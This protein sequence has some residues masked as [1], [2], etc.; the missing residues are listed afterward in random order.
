MTSTV[1]A[2]Q[3]RD[4]RPPFEFGYWLQTNVLSLGKIITLLLLIALNIWI[5]GAGM[6]A[7]P[8]TTTAVIMLWSVFGGLIAYNMVRHNHV[9]GTLREVKVRIYTSLHGALVSLFLL[10][11]L[12]LALYA[13]VRYVTFWPRWEAIVVNFRLLMVGRYPRALTWRPVAAALF[14]AALGVASLLT[15]G[16][17]SRRLFRYRKVMIGLWLASPIILGIILYGVGAAYDAPDAGPLGTVNTRL[18]G[19]LMLTLIISVVAI[20]VSF[21][22]GVSLAL[23]RQSHYP[24]VKYFCIGYIE[25]IRGVPLITVL[26]MAEFMLPLFLPG[27]LTVDSL[28]RV[29]VGFTL[30]SAAYL[31]ENVRGGLQAVP[32]GQY[33]AAYAVG[34][35]TYQTTRRIILPQALRAVIPA[36]VGQFIGLFK[37]TSLVAI[38]GVFDLLS[39]GRAVLGQQEYRSRQAEI[40]LFVGLIYFVGASGMSYA[41]RRLETRLGVGE[42]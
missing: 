29:T 28:I 27:G 12:G 11:V 24:V 21:P 19:G 23:G 35:N 22:L 14:V 10:V 36:I 41:S 4:D 3:R 26:F 25:L 6:Q 9:H 34:L 30:F 16:P 32:R 42:R 38:I 5:I 8:L 37:D 13:F 31:A 1:S 15:W 18:W 33:E 40:Y 7:N 17:V 20:V 2:M 39:I